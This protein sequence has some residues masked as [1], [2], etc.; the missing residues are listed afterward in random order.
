MNSATEFNL[1][2]I[3][4]IGIKRAE[5]VKKYLAENGIALADLATRP[6]QWFTTTL[7][8]PHSVAERL[9]LALQVWFSDPESIE[10]RQRNI[11]LIR[12]G[13]KIYPKRLIQV[14]GD[15][16]PDR[17]YVWGN[18]ELLDKP[19]VGFCGSRDVSESGL[20]LTEAISAEIVA[21]QWVVVS[22]HARGVDVTAHQTALQRG[23]TTII[24]AAEGIL[25]F[26]L[27]AAI[28]ALVKTGNIL[29]ISEFSPRAGWN[30]GN[31]MTRNR[32]IIGLS[33]AMVLIESRLEG[34]TFEAGKA[35]LKLN[36]PLFVAPSPS[37][38]HLAPG[39]EHF[40]EQGAEAIQSV[41]SRLKLSS[42]MQRVK[43]SRKST[44]G[45]SKKIQHDEMQMQLM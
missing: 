33:D 17:L 13:D 1:R 20:A 29:I 21:E 12:K 9:I 40:I 36:V 2:D 14:L 15:K 39:N 32:T 27:K 10:L 4:G 3:S 44:G 28:K 42:L 41:K 7:Q 18:L 31:A 43:K 11:G 45:S 24:V 23:G 16:A 37:K 35:A 30:V 5:K 22:G 19:S 8:V 26:K 38:E 25:S 34:G 6:P